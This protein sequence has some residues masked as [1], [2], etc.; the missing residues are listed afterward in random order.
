QPLVG[1]RETER[2]VVV[3]VEV[4]PQLLDGDVRAAGDAAGAQVELDTQH[5]ANDREVGSGDVVDCDE[6]VARVGLAPRHRRQER[7]HRC[8]RKYLSEPSS[9]CLQVHLA[10]LPSPDERAR[11]A[12]CPRSGP[13]LD[14]VASRRWQSV[15]KEKILE[16]VWQRAEPS[17][18]PGEWRWLGGDDPAWTHRSG[19]PAS[20]P[21]SRAAGAGQTASW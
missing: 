1:A 19:A 12:S 16:S 21:L 7:R 15:V 13:T 10:D 2:E 3:A 18:T 4:E 9:R 11:A 8:N 6:S 20:F 14:D 17:E 5:V